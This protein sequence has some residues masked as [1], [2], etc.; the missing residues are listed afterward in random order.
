MDAVGVTDRKRVLDGKAYETCLRI[1]RLTASQLVASAINVDGGE[2]FHREQSGVSAELCARAAA[3]AT[4]IFNAHDDAD[5]IARGDAGVDCARTRA[6][7]VTLFLLID[8]LEGGEAARTA[9]ARVLLRL[10][11]VFC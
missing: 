10:T 7:F 9:H 8:Y 4:S 11:D 5:I 6:L 2:K 3:L 1:L